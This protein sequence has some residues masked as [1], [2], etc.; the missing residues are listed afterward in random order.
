MFW[1]ASRPDDA[2]NFSQAGG[3]FRLEKAD[4][5]WCSMPYSERMRYAAFVYNREYIESRWDKQWGDRMNEIVFIGQDMNKTEMMTDLE[6]CLLQDTEQY[7][8][9]NKIQF[10]DPFPE[11]I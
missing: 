6:K 7:L 11:G 3:S 10:S 5:W 2:I 9:D 1:L 8:F 4:I